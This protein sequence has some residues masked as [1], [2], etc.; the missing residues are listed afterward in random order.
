MF[1][2]PFDFFIVRIMSNVVSGSFNLFKPFFPPARCETLETQQGEG[3]KADTAR[4]RPERPW[5]A[6]RTMEVLIKAVSPRHCAATSAPR[7]CCFTEQP[8]WAESQGQCPLHCCWGTTRSE[9][10]L[11]FTAQLHLPAQDLFCANLRVQLHL[12]AL[13]LSS[14]SSNWILMACQPHR[15][16]SG[17]SNSGHKQIH[18]SKLFS[19]I[20]IYINPLSSQSTKPITSQT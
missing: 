6:A 5:T 10:S 2:L 1:V 11:T 17:Q 8:C 7:S 18:I 9:R 16:T 19:H 4:K 3:V 13:Y 12:P 20:Y 15:V 14:S